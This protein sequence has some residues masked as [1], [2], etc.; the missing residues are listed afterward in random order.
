[1]AEEHE[2]AT[3]RLCQWCSTPAAEDAAS[4][5][6]CGAALAARESIGDL[7]I[8]GVT[9]VDP[10][11]QAL[12][13]QPFRLRG[14]SPSHGVASSVIVAAA[15]GGPIGLAALGGIAAVAAVEFAGASRGHGSEAIELEALGRPSEAALLALGHLPPE[16]PAAATGETGADVSAPDRTWDDLPPPTDPSA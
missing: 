6:S 11:L 4:C 12:D 10:A 13:A 1:M 16:L 2:P 8:P 14:P 3:G 9:A 5:A 15:A 7:V